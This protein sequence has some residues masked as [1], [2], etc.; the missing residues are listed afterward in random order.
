MAKGRPQVTH[1][2]L[3]LQVRNVGEGHRVVDAWLLGQG[4][5]GLWAR[6]ARSSRRRFAGALNPF[7]EL[8]VTVTP[9]ENLW[10]LEAVDVRVDRHGIRDSLGAIG[11]AA[12]LCRV[13]QALWPS[14]QDADGVFEGLTVALDH[15]AAL[16]LPR[17]AGL[18]PRL[19]QWAGLMPS[20]TFCG[21]CQ[22]SAQQLTAP[23]GRPY[24]I[25]S[26]CAP[27]EPPLAPEVRAALGGARIQEEPVAARVEAIVTEWV[28]LFTGKK[29]TPWMAQALPTGGHSP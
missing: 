13:V 16:R 24:L 15:L 26:A 17:A 2:A 14:G 3:V 20:L 27:H 28:S 18:Y 1:R 21:Q 10:R 25:C 9:E 23:S 5:I 4:R 19:A 12:T 8:L 11:R 7:T 22:R 29:L 6:N